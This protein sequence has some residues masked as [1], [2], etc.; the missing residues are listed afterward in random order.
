MFAKDAAAKT[1]YDTAEA[2]LATTNAQIG[3]VEAQLEQ[4]K[5]S[6]DTA[7][8]NLGYTKIVAPMDGKV[9]AIVTQQGATVNAN[10]SA[11][12]IIRLADLSTVTVKAQISEADVINVKRGQHLYFTILGDA[13]KKYQATLL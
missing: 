13:D 2:N 4:G 9:V 3:A 12:I 5:I 10:Q 6:V 1:D 7:R 11:P 8:V